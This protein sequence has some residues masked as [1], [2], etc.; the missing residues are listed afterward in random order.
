MT[1]LLAQSALLFGEPGVLRAHLP[2]RPARLVLGWLAQGYAQRRKLRSPAG[3]VYRR[4]EQGKP[5]LQCYLEAPEKFLPQAYLAAIGL[6]VQAL[7]QAQD[8]GDPGEEEPPEEDLLDPS[9]LSEVNG[10]T[11]LSAWEQA[12]RLLQGELSPGRTQAYLSEAR[13]HA[14]EAEGRLAVRAAT[15]Y[16]RDWLQARLGRT[17]ERMLCGILDREVRVVFEWEG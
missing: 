8:P 9:L 3:L 10:R 14:W 13:P 11:V 2:A 7:P 17:L 1:A 5:P 12:L 6:P 15:P 16:A 4:L